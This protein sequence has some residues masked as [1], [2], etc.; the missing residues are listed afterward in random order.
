MPFGSGSSSGGESFLTLTPQIGWTKRRSHFSPPLKDPVSSEEPGTLVAG[1]NLSAHL[2]W[3]PMF[4]TGIGL[5][6]YRDDGAISVDLVPKAAT[7]FGILGIG[8]GGTWRDGEVGTVVEGWAALLAGIRTRATYVDNVKRLS[9]TLF[10][11][12]PLPI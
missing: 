12:L 11:A 8:A 3:T 4:T 9:T 2:V 6:V 5:G 7:L 10:I 1:L